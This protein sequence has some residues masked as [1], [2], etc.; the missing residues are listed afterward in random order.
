MATRSVN[1]RS[2]D[3]GSEKELLGGQGRIVQRREMDDRRQ[4]EETEIPL[5]YMSGTTREI[6]VLATQRM[7]TF[8]LYCQD[9]TKIARPPYHVS[10]YFQQS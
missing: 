1:A 7:T 3:R 5:E 2:S 8:T 10:P 4:R 9:L 6:S